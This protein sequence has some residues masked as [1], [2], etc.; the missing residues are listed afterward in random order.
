MVEVNRRVFF[1]L[2]AAAGVSAAIIPSII[3]VRPNPLPSIF[4][5][6]KVFPGDVL[7]REKGKSW[8]RIGVIDEIKVII[9]TIDLEI[10]GY[11]QRSPVLSSKRTFL[12]VKGIDPKFLNS[13][14]DFLEICVVSHEPGYHYYSQR[15]GLMSIQFQSDS[16]NR[17]GGEAEFSLSN[18]E[19]RKYV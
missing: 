1:S 17:I 10:D 2:A 11:L 12:W 4:P 19:H 14:Y 7:I 13:F 3:E 15:A 18:L 6:S 16:L 5:S 8:E 9:D